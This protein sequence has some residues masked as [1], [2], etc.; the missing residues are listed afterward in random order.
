[1]WEGISYTGL[2]LY[3]QMENSLCNMDKRTLVIK[4]QSI[5]VCFLINHR[6][7]SISCITSSVFSRPSCGIIS[8]SNFPAMTW[9]RFLWPVKPRKINLSPP[10]STTAP[11]FEKCRSQSC[12]QRDLRVFWR[13]KKPW[14]R[15]GIFWPHGTRLKK[16]TLLA[17][18]HFHAFFRKFPGPTLEK[19]CVNI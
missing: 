13:R 5:K 19:S 6:T 17:G 8:S 15:S 9:R 18:L 4:L 1:M 16:K 12:C 2:R 7:I 3:N 10:S 14:M 11:G